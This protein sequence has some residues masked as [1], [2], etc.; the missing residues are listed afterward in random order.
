MDGTN[1]ANNIITTVAGIGKQGYS[2]D[3]GAATEAK[4]Y[5]PYG[6][7]LDAV[8]NLYIADYES[9]RI[10]KVAT[11]GIITTFAGNG[12]AGYSGDGGAATSESVYFPSGVAVDAAENLYIADQGNNRIRKVGT[13]GIITTV[14]GGSTGGDGVPATKARLTAPS[15]V[16]CDSAGNLY[17]AD[18]GDSG[19]RKVSTNGIITTVAGNGNQG[20]SGDGGTATNASLNTPVAVALDA[21]GELYIADQDNNRIRMVDTNGIITTVAGDGPL[22]PSAGTYSGDGGAA[23]N[24]GLNVPSGVAVDS[25]GSIYIADGANNR[26]RKVDTTGSI[27]TLAGN[28][29][30]A[31]AGDGGLATNASLNGPYGVALDASDN[32]FIG[33]S[34]NGSVRKVLLYAGFPTF[35]LT[36]VGAINAGSYTVVVTSPYGSVTSAVASLTVEAPPLITLEPTGQFGV[37]GGIPEFT[38]AVAGSGPFE[39]SWYLDS[40]N[41]LQSGTNSTLTVASIST[42]DGGDYSVVVTN[43]YG[44]VTSLLARLTVG[45]PPSV[46]T[47]PINQTALAGSNVTLNVAAGGTGPFSYQ[48][49]LNGTNLP[50]DIITTVAGN[51]IAA[52]AGDGGPATNASLYEPVGVALDAS[53]NLYIADKFSDRIR[54]VDTNGI[55]TSVGTSNAVAYASGLALDA[56]GNAYFTAAWLNMVF[57][58]TTN[59]N[60]TAVAG[61]GLIGFSGDGGAA[62]GAQLF[63]PSGVALDASANLYF[64]DTYNNRIRKIGAN[65]IINTVAGNGAAAY[66]GDGSA[67]TN[68]SLN[69]P[70]GVAIDAAGDLYIADQ[71]NNCIRKVSADGIVTTVAGSGEE[72]YSG[73]GGPA[74]DASLIAPSSVALDATG[75][76]YIADTGNPRVRKVGT[77][78]IITTVAGNGEEG[79]SGDGGAATNASFSVPVILALDASGNL[80]MDDVGNNRIREVP[81]AGY[82][83]LNLTDVTTNNAGNYTVVISSPYGSVTSA[84]VTLNVVTSP[85]EIITCDGFFGLLSSQFGFDLGGAVGQ[86]IVVDGSIDLVNW[87]PLC[88]NA[89]SGNPVY[90]CDPAWTNFPW[91]FYRAR[92]PQ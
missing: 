36:N 69:K 88:T 4:M 54:K 72:G 51:G 16:A 59:G 42:N 14:A 76:L 40:T 44:S 43:A 23:T 66:S 84:V 80:F 77:N 37:V 50:N 74:K 63:Y 90:F 85:P 56:V 70:D 81:F 58:M 2:G 82:P 65:G 47:Q 21:A 60:F 10:R 11:N 33:D 38:V 3:G 71:L 87:T 67:A 24:A 30:K 86:T 78:G 75:N 62:I 27:T 34:G 6:V 8:G 89:V 46:T 17:I 31:Y 35:I 57:K 22:W 41:L 7:A 45:F 15:G 49:Q 9:C 55:I 68:A 13:N 61:S 64:A 73:D 19:I 39:Y 32:L 25:F 18:T 1:F 12:N 91:R 28:G 26:I 79:Y 53:G 52:Y 29:S 92:V 83:S 5:H 20:Y 48:W